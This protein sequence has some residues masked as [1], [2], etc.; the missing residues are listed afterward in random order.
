MRPKAVSILPIWLTLHAING[1]ITLE[2]V[3]QKVTDLELKVNTLEV[4][5]W[6]L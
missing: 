6:D 1:D 5:I 2:S 3:F 4:I